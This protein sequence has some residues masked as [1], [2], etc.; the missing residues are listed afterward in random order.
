MTS[1]QNINPWLPYAKSSPRAR[2]R[3]FCFAYAGK[4]ASLFR[5]WASKLPAE[6]EVCP[7]EL[8]GRGSRIMEPPFTRLTPLVETLTQIL[9][10]YL[11]MPFA[12]FGHSMGG[13]VSF[14]LARQL[15]RQCIAQ[16]AH[17]LISAYRAPQ[18]SDS[19]S[20]I[21][22]L[23]DTQF[24]GKVRLLGGMPQDILGNT[25]LMHL[26]LPVLRTDFALC[27]T[28]IYKHEEPFS[29]PISAFG[30]LQDSGVSQ[31]QLEAWREQTSDTFSLHMCA[32]DHFYLH[33]LEESLLRTIT[34]KLAPYL[35]RMVI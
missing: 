20:P 6:I 3:L 8:P 22:E 19:H 33:T 35:N 12:F 2:L 24:M 16:P 25:E 11:T 18:L 34:Q 17:L 10:P 13:L 14:E 9:L 30:G 1:N 4:G 21:H 28:Y 15:R 23:P 26:V 32:G 7:I 31:S 27:E 29:C 5:S